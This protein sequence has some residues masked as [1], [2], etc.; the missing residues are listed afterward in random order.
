MLTHKKLREH[1]S[2][3]QKEVRLRLKEFSI[4]SKDISDKKLFLELC[5]CICTPQ[6]KAVKVAEVIN[7]NNIDKLINLPQI[8]LAELL[9]KN[10][11]FH[12]N[13]AKH[14]INARSYINEIF[15]L[16]NSIK[17]GV[18]VR[19]FLVKNI[20]GIGY[21]EASHYLRNIGYRDLCII[22]RHVITLMHEL[23][24]FNDLSTPTTAKKYLKMEQEIK[25]YAKKHGYDVDELDLVLWS[26]KTGHVFK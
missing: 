11:R 6:S 15:V 2:K 25:D 17:D 10:T 1:Y 19:E 5:F 9:R 23:G 26:I 22:D 4:N 7:S 13:K 21:K 18:V 3:R 8:E 24:V 20:K 14:I 16:K 12:N